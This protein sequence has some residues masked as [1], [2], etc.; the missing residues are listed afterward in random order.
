MDWEREKP[1]AVKVLKSGPEIM[2]VTLIHGGRKGKERIN[3]RAMWK[4]LQTVLGYQ[5]VGT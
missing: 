5:L 1:E 4:E 3:S 2:K